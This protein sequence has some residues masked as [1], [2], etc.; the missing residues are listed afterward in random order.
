MPIPGIS[1]CLIVKNEET[2][3]PACLSSIRPWVDE[4]II[5]D[6]G[7]SDNTVPVAESFG[8]KIVHYK[9]SKSFSDGDVFGG[10]YIGM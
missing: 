6:T 8:A 9:W 4:I 1:A 7:S 5:V 10:A 2:N 3:L